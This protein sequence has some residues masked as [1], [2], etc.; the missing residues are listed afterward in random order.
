MPNEDNYLRS[1]T[2]PTLLYLTAFA[3]WL[4]AMARFEISEVHNVGVT[5]WDV[6]AAGVILW[7]IVRVGELYDPKGAKEDRGHY[8]LFGSLI[9]IIVFGVTGMIL[10]AS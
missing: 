4:A 2:F 7:L 8:T 10:V 3:A 5:V 9:F 6:P 1:I